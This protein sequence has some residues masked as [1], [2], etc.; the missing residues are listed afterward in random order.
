MAP[1][2]IRMKNLIFIYTL[3]H[4][5]CFGFSQN[6][7]PNPSFE[8][9]N[10]CPSNFHD[11]TKFLYWSNPTNASPSIFNNCN[12]GNAGVPV[13]IAGY[14]NTHSGFGY[15]G[16]V[17]F[18]DQSQNARE[19]IQVELLS[20]LVANQKYKVRLYVNLADSSKYAINRFGIYFSQNS[21]Y[22]PTYNVINYIPQV[23]FDTLI[24]NKIDWTLLEATY[25]A[26]GGEKYITIGNFNYDS[27]CDTIL[28]GGP[29][30]TF[31]YI[32]DVYVGLDT[33]VDV[34]NEIQCKEEEITLYPNPAKERVFIKTEKSKPI[35]MFVYNM[36]G[37]LIHQQRF[38]KRT[39]IDIK[40]WP[41][42]VYYIKLISEKGIFVKKFA[43]EE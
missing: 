26:M 21:F 24:I 17:I 2:V 42:G 37:C 1:N 30:G 43:K 3:I 32:D 11:F 39:N 29:W 8:E 10:S 5:N 25:Q 31:Y 22:L 12:Q 40:N 6:L 15:A 13:N 34:N 28:L 14:Q 19:Y 23:S 38:L 7:V 33:T 41:A 27:E 35:E 16:I 18:S 9:I 20:P 36:Q 4:I